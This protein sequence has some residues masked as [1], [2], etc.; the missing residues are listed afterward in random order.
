V[1]CLQLVPPKVPSKMA[2]KWLSTAQWL[3]TPLL[4][5]PPCVSQ[6]LLECYD[7]L[8]WV[9][10]TLIDAS[11]HAR[12]RTSAH[13]RGQMSSRFVLCVSLSLLAYALISRYALSLSAFGCRHAWLGCWRSSLAFLIAANVTSVSTMVRSSSMLT[14]QHGDGN[15]SSGSPHAMG[16]IL[17]LSQRMARWAGH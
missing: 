14:K 6:L 17:K 12:C 3:S 4:A 15:F 13:A 7:W 1:V 16:A 2:A 11:R 9:F 10:L 5:P 8:S